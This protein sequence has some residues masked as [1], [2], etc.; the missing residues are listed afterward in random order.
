M[1]IYKKC[2]GSQQKKLEHSDKWS[3]HI[4]LCGRFICR[5]ETFLKYNW[6]AVK[7]WNNII[8][9]TSKSFIKNKEEYRLWI[10]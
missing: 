2:C 10:I 5:G 3:K 4:L 6:T 1:N 9:T 7:L 8:N